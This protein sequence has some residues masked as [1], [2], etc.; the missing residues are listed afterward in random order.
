MIEVRRRYRYVVEDTDRHGNVRLYLRRPGQSKI[1]LR[2]MPGTEEFDDEY[3]RAMN[4]EILPREPVRPVIVDGSLR[5]LCV[6]YHRSPEAA[7]LEARTRHV[8]RLILDGLCER[9]GDW[10]A[11]QMEP[12][13]IRKLRDQKPDKPEAGNAIVK[14]LR[15]VFKHGVLA[16]LVQGNPAREV[17][18]I[19]SRGDGFHSWTPAE[20]EQ[21][22][23][24]HPVG[25]KARLAF[26]VALY[27]GQRRSDVVRLGPRHLHD[28][29]LTFTQVKNGRSKPVTLT[30]P[31]VPELARIIAATPGASSGQ[32]FLL[33]ERGTPYTAESFGNKFREWCNEAGLPHCASH[34]LRKAA[35]KRLAE[36]GCTYHEIA[37][38]TG[39]RSL[40]EVQ[41]YTLGADQKRLAQSALARLQA[42]DRKG[43]MSHLGENAVQWGKNSPQPIE[44]E[45]QRKC[46]VPKGGIEPPTL[47]FSVACSTN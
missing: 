13:H 27:T 37:A 34:G 17:E 43:E 14:A 28:G 44:I 36:L 5:A 18:Y 22:E 41:R 33:S 8:R 26:A 35:A 29:L 2:C 40:K 31:M 12:K 23:A 9:C 24:T 6:S 32:A 42:A 19:R 21:Y 15:A 39:H 25:S 20:V 16:G 10:P 3:R 46:V 45:G 11:D 38:V 1:R 4:G 47:R 7:R 30:L